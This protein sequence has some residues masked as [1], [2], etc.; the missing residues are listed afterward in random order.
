MR[1]T[2]LA[3]WI[4]VGLIISF[5][6]GKAIGVSD[7]KQYSYKRM[8]STLL[9]LCVPFGSIGVALGCCVDRWFYGFWAIPFLGNIHF[10]VLLGKERKDEFIVSICCIYFN[11]HF[12][13]INLSNSLFYS[14]QGSLYGTHPFLWYVFAGIPAIC[15]IMLL[16]TLRC[17]HIQNTRNFVSY[18]RYYPSFAFW[19]VMPYTVWSA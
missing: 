7:A 18:F 1:F 16:R 4:P 9:G 8:L 3:A 11:T 2:A 10:N 6:S 15:G 14:G 19:P 13:H 12:N 5:N 17:T